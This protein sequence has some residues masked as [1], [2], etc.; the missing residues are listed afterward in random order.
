MSQ[1]TMRGIQILP[2]FTGNS[3]DCDQIS[4][5]VD[6]TGVNY[7]ISLIFNSALPENAQLFVLSEIEALMIID[8]SGQANITP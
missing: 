6:G 2:N 4:V 7:S 1:K 8:S 5:P 3:A